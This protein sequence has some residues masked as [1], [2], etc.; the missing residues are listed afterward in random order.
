M[1]LPQGV[2]IEINLLRGV[3]KIDKMIVLF[4]AYNYKLKLFDDWTSILYY[5]SVSFK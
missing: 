2:G 3:L 1:S 5:I 4:Y